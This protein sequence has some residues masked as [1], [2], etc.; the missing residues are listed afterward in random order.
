[1]PEVDQRP[2]AFLA[3]RLYIP[4]DMATKWHKK[5]FTYVFGPEYADADSDIEAFEETRTYREFASGYVGFARGNL[6]KIQ[7]VFG[8]DFRI[9][10]QRK[11][12][13]HGYDLQFTGELTAEQLRV[14]T[15]WLEFQYGVIEAPPRW[16]K[17][18]MMTY[19]LTKLKQKALV[20]AQEKSLLHQFEEEMRAFTNI[21]DLE[22]RHNKRLIGIPRKGEEIMPI[23]T[24]RT[25][26]VYDRRLPEL[27]RHRDSWGAVFVDEAHS[28]SAP[29][30]ARVVNTTNSYYRIAVTA[31][32]ERKDGHHVV[33][34]DVCGPVVAK[35]RTEQL[36]V[37][38]KVV[39]TNAKWPPSRLRGKAFW[40]ECLRRIMRHERRN[41]LICK[42]VLADARAGYYVLVT[43]DRIEHIYALSTMMRWMDAKYATT[44]GRPKMKIA[45]LHGKL[46][47]EAKT[48][49]QNK[50]D[51]WIN[52]RDRKQLR[53]DAKAGKLN[54]VIAY[55][56]IVQLG[57]NVPLWSSLHSVMPMANKPNW[58]QR[59]S[60]VRTKCANCPGV[61]HPD[62]MKKGLCLKKPPICH[63]YVDASKVSRGCFAVQQ[64][65]H[66]KLGFVEQVDYEDVT[67]K[68]NRDPERKGKLILWT[69][70]G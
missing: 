14:W 56:K 66:E 53:L 63:I 18:I 36:P 39:K 31:T 50:F 64:Q 54:I 51:I 68:V 6:Q 61:K 8:D 67:V 43:T 29:C 47:P 69:E 20:L 4:E 27:R 5:E 19:M 59:I 21:N 55:S 58:Y 42:R 12:V 25:W 16:G 3:S 44:H 22:R 33:M 46:K 13:P 10:D 41:E 32:P 57:W 7:K 45:E 70:I 37:H 40:A 2:K 49:I 62:C 1:M 65:V 38:V 9:V 60:R 17:T 35:G 26:Q 48:R 11:L 34:L 15:Q 24:F 52:E 23:A 30:F 28:A